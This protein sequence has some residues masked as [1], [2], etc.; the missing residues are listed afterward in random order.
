MVASYILPRAGEQLRVGRM[1]LGGNLDQTS[2]GGSERG[3]AAR[4]YGCRCACEGSQRSFNVWE[5]TTQQ[6]DKRAMMCVMVR[7]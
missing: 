1:A 5:T 4:T 2:A 3:C 7:L 6:S